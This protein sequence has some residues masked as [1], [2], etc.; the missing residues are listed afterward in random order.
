MKR[1]SALA[2]PQSRLSLAGVSVCAQTLHSVSQ[3]TGRGSR[4]L[5]NSSWAERS[6]VIVPDNS[7]CQKGALHP[8]PGQS[9][10]EFLNGLS[11]GS[12]VSELFPQ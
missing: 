8:I 9:V 12:C 11:E 2:K 5:P 4:Y 1:L 3:L 7:Y 10:Q 6:Y